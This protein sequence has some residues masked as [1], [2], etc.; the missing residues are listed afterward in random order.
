M[1]R[2]R[3]LERRLAAVEVAL[4]GPPPILVEYFCTG[5]YTHEIVTFRGGGAEEHETL[6]TPP[7]DCWSGDEDADEG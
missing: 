7:H 3:E 4:I 5:G 6:E 2:D 1:P